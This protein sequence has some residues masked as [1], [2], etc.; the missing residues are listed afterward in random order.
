MS[1][2]ENK[3]EKDFGSRVTQSRY[4]AISIICD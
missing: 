4:K 2:T 3:L 1:M